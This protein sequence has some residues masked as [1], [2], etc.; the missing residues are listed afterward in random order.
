LDTNIEKPSRR[1]TIEDD[2]DSDDD[3]LSNFIV[4]DEEEEEEEE[5][6]VERRRYE[7]HIRHDKKLQNESLLFPSTALN[8]VYDIFG[9]GLD[10]A[11][12]LPTEK[13]RQQEEYGDIEDDEYEEKAQPS[14][15]LEEAFEP[16]EIIEKHFTSFYRYSRTNSR[17]SWKSH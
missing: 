17:A 1:S 10:Y 11:Y 3:D 8:D 12:A 16:S 9:N 6:K 14:I 13:G 2:F 4:A 7:S 5:S 15:T